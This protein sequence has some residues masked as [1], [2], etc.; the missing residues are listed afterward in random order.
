MSAP[1][2]T[3]LVHLNIETRASTPTIEDIEREVNGALEVGTDA[4]QTPWL[5]R[6]EVVIALAEE[7]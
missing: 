6:S 5:A 3:F 4:A 7:V 1:I 2:R